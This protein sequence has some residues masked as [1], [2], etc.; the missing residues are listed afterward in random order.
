MAYTKQRSNKYFDAFNKGYVQS[1]NRT[2]ASELIETLQKSTIPTLEKI[3]DYNIKKDKNEAATKIAQLESQGKDSKT[4]IAEM[5]EGLHPELSG[6]YVDKTVQY[7]LGRV[8]ASKMKLRVMEDMKTNYDFKTSNIDTFL[9]TYMQEMDFDNKD[10]SFSLG[11]ASTFTPFK[12]EIMVKDAENRANFNYETKILDLMSLTNAIPTDEIS[13]TYFQTLNSAQ[14]ELP[15]GEGGTFIMHSNDDINKAAMTDVENIIKSS[16]TSKELLRAFEILNADRGFAKDG[17]KLQSFL[18][19]NK[20]EVKKLVEDYENK[21]RV[22]ENNEYTI[23]QREIETDKKERLSTLFTMDASSPDFNEFRDSLIAD[24]PSMAVTINSI[25]TANENMAEDKGAIGQIDRNIHLG[26]YNNNMELLLSDLAKNNASKTTILNSIK[27]LA[28]AELRMNSGFTSPLLDAE[29]TDTVKDIASILANN[30][31][32]L[33]SF[34]DNRKYDFMVDTIE[35]EL[36]D[37]W[38][39]WNTDNPKPSASESREIQMQWVKDSKNWLNGEYEKL[40]KKY[41]NTTWGEAMAARIENSGLTTAADIDSYAQEYYT[42]VLTKEIKG[43][44]DANIVE[45]LIEESK[46]DL[47]PV[48]QKI[49]ESDFMSNLMS[50]KGFGLFDDDTSTPDINERMNVVMDIMEGLG[51][52]DVDFTDDVNTVLDNINNFTNN[53]DLPEITK[54]FF[55]F[56]DQ[57]SVEAQTNAFINGINTLAGRPITKEFYNF[58]IA[59]QNEDVKTNMAQAFGVATEQLDELVNKYLK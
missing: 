39:Q 43:L 6:K 10:D 52:D 23:N 38:L 22:L 51:I 9:S 50:T 54:D 11:F 44:K 56:T 40:I 26:A 32:K 34:D 17:K 31:P 13:E 4:I 18:F 58:Y 19:S 48:R 15:N 41:D 36:G 8:E 59:N 5:N 25:M 1:S 12:S 2:D 46:T 42:E 21:A 49:L 45:S 20:P 53:I 24:Y 57:D 7:H 28:S 33:S 30:I 14:Y 47:I 35:N 16:K 29:Y 37:K 27:S 55:F 3:Q